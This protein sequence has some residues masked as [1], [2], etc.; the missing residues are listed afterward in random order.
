VIKKMNQ[1][2]R[3]TYSLDDAL[4]EIEMVIQRLIDQTELIVSQHLNNKDKMLH[5]LGN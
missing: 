5:T 4:R 2:E 3:D 1:Y